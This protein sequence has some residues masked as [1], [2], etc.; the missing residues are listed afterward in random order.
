M[1]AAR[2]AAANSPP[3]LA[4]EL[5]FWTPFV[6]IDEACAIHALRRQALQVGGYE[7]DKVV[8]TSSIM[9]G[10]AQSPG[11]RPRYHQ[12]VGTGSFLNA[13][14]IRSPSTLFMGSQRARAIALKRRISTGASFVHSAYCRSLGRSC[15]PS[16]W[17]SL[18]ALGLGRSND[19]H[20][21]MSMPGFIASMPRIS[22]IMECGGKS[23][24]VPQSIRPRISAVSL[25]PV[26]ASHANILI[27]LVGARRFELPTPCSRSK[28]PSWRYPCAL[29]RGRRI[30][31]RY[32]WLRAPDLNLPTSPQGPTSACARWPLQ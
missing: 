21:R 2:K 30:A 12:S 16:I 10:R 11:V 7:G 3:T 31:V 8:R 15:R 17:L 4:T 19:R 13:S 25:R 22:Y 29:V 23:F 26:S 20:L 1:G 14:L 6:V 24:Q 9:R 32:R 5:G 28:C 18:V 27:L